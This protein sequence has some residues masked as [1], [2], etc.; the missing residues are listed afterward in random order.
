MLLRQ[1]PGVKLEPIACEK[2]QRQPAQALLCEKSGTRPAPT[3]R[4]VTLIRACPKGQWQ[5][6]LALLCETLGATLKSII[7]R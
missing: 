5:S 3:A 4:H 7:P 6:A 2:G 1:M